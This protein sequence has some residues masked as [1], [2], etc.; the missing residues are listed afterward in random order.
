MPSYCLP[1]N[2]AV[3]VFFPSQPDAMILPEEPPSQPRVVQVIVKQEG[4]STINDIATYFLAQHDITTAVESVLLAH[5]TSALPPTITIEGKGYVLHG[6]RKEWKY[7]RGLQ[8]SWGEK[9][10][11][12]C[13]DKW[14]FVFAPTPVV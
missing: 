10:V 13:D 7:G 5:L 2:K 4:R 14:I 12:A 3:L 6:V 9:D 1:L 11:H 8:L